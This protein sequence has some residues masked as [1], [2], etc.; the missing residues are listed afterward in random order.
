MNAVELQPI[1]VLWKSIMKR[2]L[3][4]MAQKENAL[5]VKVS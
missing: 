4:G 3:L 2:K 5:S 1:G